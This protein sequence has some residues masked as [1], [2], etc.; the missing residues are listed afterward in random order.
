MLQLAELE[1]ILHRD[2]KLKLGKIAEHTVCEKK[3]KALE[4]VL[5]TAAAKTELVTEAVDHMLK[6]YSRIA[7]VS[8]LSYSFQISIPVLLLP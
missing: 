7:E 3:D 4:L 8:F 5:T 2:A 1:E 6:L